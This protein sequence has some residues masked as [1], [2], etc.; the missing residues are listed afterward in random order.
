MLGN[1]L[2]LPEMEN[3]NGKEMKNALCS[4]FSLLESSVKKIKNKKV[5]KG[6]SERVRC[7]YVQYTQ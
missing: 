6:K 1:K 5:K 3:K 2:T 4:H 7:T